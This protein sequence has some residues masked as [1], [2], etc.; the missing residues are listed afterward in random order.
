MVFFRDCCVVAVLAQ[1]RITHTLLRCVQARLALTKKSS[2]GG[3][4]YG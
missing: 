3:Y 2:P 4:V 1:S